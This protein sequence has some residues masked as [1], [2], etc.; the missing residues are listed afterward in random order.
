M[1][2]WSSVL[3][4]EYT[5]IRAHK[6]EQFLL[7][8]LPL[9]LIVLIWWIFSSGQSRDLPLAVLDLDQ[10]QLSRQLSRTLDASPALSVAE[11]NGEAT[12]KAEA[13]PRLFITTLT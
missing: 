5:F 6:A 11:G 2:A 9:L 12:K 8:G 13:K 10:S 3:A 7:F 4:R 1:S